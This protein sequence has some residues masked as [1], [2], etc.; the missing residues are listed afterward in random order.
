MHL[1]IAESKKTNSEECT[2]VHIHTYNCVFS[3]NIHTLYV[4]VC[5]VTIY[6]PPVHLCSYYLCRDVH[7]EK[8]KGTRKD[9]FT[10]GSVDY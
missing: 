6:I 3:Q 2:N 8:I 9:L 1:K 4:Y 10:L 7:K 5:I